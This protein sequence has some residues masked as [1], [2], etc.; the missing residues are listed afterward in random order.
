MFPPTASVLSHRRQLCQRWTRSFKSICYL[1]VDC[2]TLSTSSAAD[3]D[4]NCPFIPFTRLA[5]PRPIRDAIFSTLVVPST[6]E[7]WGGGNFP[8][9]WLKK[10]NRRLQ[11]NRAIARSYAVMERDIVGNIVQFVGRENCLGLLEDGRSSAIVEWNALKKSRPK[12]T[13]VRM[14]LSVRLLLEIWDLSLGSLQS[15]SRFAG[16]AN[17]GPW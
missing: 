4:G 16:L 10:P 17:R 13:Y 6:S 5:Q 7:M 15:P 3:L 1:S 14:Y 9:R 8:T 2:A 11:R 12:T